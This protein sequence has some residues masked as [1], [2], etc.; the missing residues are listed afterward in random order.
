M[1]VWAYLDI[2]FSLAR[3]PL[4]WVELIWSPLVLSIY[5]PNT[6]TS[7]TQWCTS[8][9]VVSWSKQALVA[10]KKLSG[11]GCSWSLL[12]TKFDP[13]LRSGICR[14]WSSQTL[15][16]PQNFSPELLVPDPHSSPGSSRTNR[17]LPQWKPGARLGSHRGRGRA[18]SLCYPYVHPSLLSIKKS[19]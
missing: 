13:Y 4:T 5:G 18:S 3:E 19:M 17:D 7:W 1:A 14:S 6:K 11:S 16:D 10:S 12:K 2:I 9:L 15:T 8:D